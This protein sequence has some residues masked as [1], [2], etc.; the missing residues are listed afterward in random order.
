MPHLLIV[1][2]CMLLTT[3]SSFL[4]KVLADGLEGLMVNFAILRVKI[5]GETILVL[6][7]CGIL[8]AHI[9]ANQADFVC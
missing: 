7:S 5:D 8:G 2:C 3:C 1:L 9:T 6:A 4:D